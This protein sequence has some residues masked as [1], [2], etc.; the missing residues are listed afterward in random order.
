M[1]KMSTIFPVTRYGNGITN[2][3]NM[4]EE[5]DVMFDNMLN[6][7]ITSRYQPTA[8]VKT[9]TV[10]RANILKSEE[11][12]TVELAAPG[13][14]RDEFAIKVEDDILSIAVSTEDNQ[15]F[16]EMAMQEYHYGSW[17]RSWTLPNNVNIA[18][19]EARYEAGILKVYV[20]TEGTQSRTLQIEVK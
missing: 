13:F 7:V 20:P 10:P 14:S 8:S 2:F 16:D 6:S 5:I 15:E 1:I 3:T 19:I 4:F 11:G 17:K 12:Y 18:A 9:V